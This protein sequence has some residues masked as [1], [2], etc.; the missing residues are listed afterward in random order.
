MRRTARLLRDGW[1]HR[2]WYSKANREIMR[3]SDKHGHDPAWVAAAL[4]VASPRVHVA[5]SVTIAK[6]WLHNDE[7][8]DDVLPNVRR[9]FE[10]LEQEGT[11]RGRKTYPFYRALIGDHDALV[12]DVWMARAYR[13]KQSIVTRDYVS[14][15][16][17]ADVSYLARR[18][19]CTMRQA[20]AA[21]WAG[22]MLDNGRYPSNLE[23]G[24]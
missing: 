6:H 4:A 11:I 22:T 17:L 2:N 16:I 24:D 3:W 18:N 19:R 12:L 23:M 13:V 8:P 9:S 14:V 10:I 20:Q 21:I 15:D 7:L 1:Q 5:K